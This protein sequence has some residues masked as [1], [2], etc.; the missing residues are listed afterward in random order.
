MIQAPLLFL[1]MP[2]FAA[3]R[4]VALVVHWWRHGD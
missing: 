2:L 1:L 3:V 4:L